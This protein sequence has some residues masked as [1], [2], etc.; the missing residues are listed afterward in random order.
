MTGIPGESASSTPSP[1]EPADAD[2]TFPEALVGSLLAVSQ[3]RD[4]DEALERT[5]AEAQRIFDARTA[6]I[7]LPS[8]MPV[9][10][11]RE[12]Q[13][14]IRLPLRDRDAEIA[15]LVLE[16]DE[17]F[18][19]AELSRATT[20]AAFAARAVE[21][22]RL[23]T[24]AHA[25]EQ[26]RARLT[27]RLITAEQDERRRLSIFLHDGPLQAMSGIALMHDA[28]LAA[29]EEG[30]YDDAARVIASSLEHERQTIRTLRDLSFA[31]EPVIL[32]DRGFAAAVRALAEQVEG[33]HGITVVTEVEAGDLLGE[34]AQVALYQL[35]RE[36]LE[37]A[38]RRKP[39]RIVV[40]VRA[41]DGGL[42]T[43]VRDDGIGERRRRG[44]DELA[45][46]VAVLNGSVAMDTSPEDGTT[47]RVVLPAYA[48][49]TG[50][51]AQP[52]ETGVEPG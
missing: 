1:A 4:P 26:E 46:R 43:E 16:R 7:V 52:P 17:P 8:E 49:A 21:N 36:A 30:R 19:P 2:S 24:E 32:R 41:E 33:S 37:Q 50:S 9:A 27:E 12:T 38:V 51:P 31:I 40:G 44:V 42:A 14:G 23:L 39:S 5:R 45:E 10:D 15:T 29:I 18:T 35:I 3:P 48:G 20:F 25:R 13:D 34:K 6:A 22:A 28:A 47:V 11:V